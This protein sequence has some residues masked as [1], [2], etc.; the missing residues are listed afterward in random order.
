MNELPRSFTLKRQSLKVIETLKTCKLQCRHNY[1]SIW[2]SLEQNAARPCLSSPRVE[3]FLKKS[4]SF[5]GLLFSFSSFSYNLPTNSLPIFSFKYCK[6]PKGYG[7]RY[8]GELLECS[9]YLPCQN[10]GRCVNSHGRNQCLCLN[11]WTGPDC[12]VNIDDWWVSFSLDLG[13]KPPDF[14]CTNFNY[15]SITS[16]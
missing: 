4:F 2:D 3:A 1:L 13:F 14:D 7:G 16:I 12:S 8:C 9:N 10:G 11:G 5:K 6:C 15:I